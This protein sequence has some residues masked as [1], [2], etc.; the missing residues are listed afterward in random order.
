MR[1]SRAVNGLLFIGLLVAGLLLIRFSIDLGAHMPLLIG[2]PFWVLVIV[3][4]AIMVWNIFAQRSEAER[5]M[6]KAEQGFFLAL[7]PLGFIVSSLDCAGFDFKGCSPFCTFVK[8]VWVPLMTAIGVI[9][10]LTKEP[11]LVAG[12]LVMSFVPLAPHCLCYNAANAWWIDRIGASP[13]C[14]VWGYTVSLIAIGACR[15]RAGQRASAAVS[16]AIIAGGL[17]FFISHHYFQF[18]W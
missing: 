10:F 3:S 5:P 13:E 2:L 1:H 11:A 9:Y 15:G 8:L 7:I 14:Y 4:L 17:G 18:P 12:L 16:M 6:S